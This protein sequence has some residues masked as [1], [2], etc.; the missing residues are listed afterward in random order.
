MLYQLSYASPHRLFPAH[1]AASPGER[2]FKRKS[3]TAAIP[4]QCIGGPLRTQR[5]GTPLRCAVPASGASA[6]R[7][8]R[9]HFCNGW[10]PLPPAFFKAARPSAEVSSGDV[11]TVLQEPPEAIAMANAAAETLSGISMITTVS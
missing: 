10:Y 4:S 9:T 1:T 7:G 11:L 3:S 2:P 8:S 5:A 6:R